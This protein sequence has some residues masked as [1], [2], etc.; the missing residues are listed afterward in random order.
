[1]FRLMY[2]NSILFQTLHQVFNKDL[3]IINRAVPSLFLH[4]TFH[5]QESEAYGS[6]ANLQGVVLN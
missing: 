3:K 2:S 6:F 5:T 1:M 4:Q